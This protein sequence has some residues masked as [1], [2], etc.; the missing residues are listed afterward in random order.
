MS[1][2]IT[3]MTDNFFRRRQRKTTL[4][5]G[6]VKKVAVVLNTDAGRMATYRKGRIVERILEAFSSRQVIPHLVLADGDSICE[7]LRSA[8]A[9]G[10]DILV[11]GGGD[12][13]V[14]AVAQILSG[15]DI[16]LG[17]LPLGTFNHLAK[18]LRI[19][20][21][22]EAAVTNIL[23]G[24]TAKIDLAEA[25]GEP[26][27]NTSTLGVVADFVKT[28]NRLRSRRGLA[29]K[30]L[31]IVHA[32]IEASIRFPLVEIRIRIGKRVEKRKTC[33]AMVGNNAFDKGLFISKGGRSALNRNRLSLYI[34][35]CGGRASMAILAIRMLIGSRKQYGDMDAILAEEL[36]VESPLDRLMI[37]AD[38]ELKWMRV[39]VRFRILPKALRV[40]TPLG[41]EDRS[42]PW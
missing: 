11:V 7:A 14:N 22:L 27:V 16:P 28:R 4:V 9:L 3:G 19:P 31:S 40:L 37:S 34:G 39:P 42:A 32:I 36:M 24:K 17:I 35:K 18:D 25:N 13:S 2:E 29:V 21:S 15:S 20:M 1:V 8:H 33:F 41:N 30:W 38:G 23:S 10:P 6:H 12:G 5:E 26:F